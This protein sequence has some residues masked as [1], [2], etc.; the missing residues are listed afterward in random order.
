MIKARHFLVSLADTAI[1]SDDVSV[2]TCAIS[3]VVVFE[4]ARVSAAKL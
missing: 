2:A 4:L 1:A 3:E